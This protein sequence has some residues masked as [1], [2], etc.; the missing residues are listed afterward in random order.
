MDEFLSGCNFNLLL[1]LFYVVTRFRVIFVHFLPC[2]SLVV[3]NYFL[4]A[5]LRRAGSVF[6]PNR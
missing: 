1:I 4:C 3:L 6:Y 2:A 5:A